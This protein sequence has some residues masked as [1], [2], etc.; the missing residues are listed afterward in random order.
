MVNLC[1]PANSLLSARKRISSFY[2]LSKL[3]AMTHFYPVFKLS[4]VMKPF[5]WHIFS[6]FINVP[7]LISPLSNPIVKCTFYFSMCG[8]LLSSDGLMSCSCRY[9]LLRHSK[10]R[11]KVDGLNNLNYSPLVSRR[12]LYTN[13]TVTLGRKLAPVADYWCQHTCPA[14]HLGIKVLWDIS[15]ITPVAAL[16]RTFFVIWLKLCSVS[17]CLN[18][19]QGDSKKFAR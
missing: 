15:H 16:L 7:M 18:A 6:S 3:Q 4:R 19:K 10:E 8:T 1:I 12:P 13:I 9:R 11:Q 2:F 17:F 5:L 14:K